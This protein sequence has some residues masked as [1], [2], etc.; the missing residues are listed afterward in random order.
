MRLSYDRVPSP[1]I[2]IEL[3]IQTDASPRCWV[4]REGERERE[5]SFEFESKPEIDLFN[6]WFMRDV[7]SEWCDLVMVRRWGGG[8]PGQEIWHY[9]QRQHPSSLRRW[10]LFDP[11]PPEEEKDHATPWPK[12]QGGGSRFPLRGEPRSRMSLLACRCAGA[13]CKWHAPCQGHAQACQA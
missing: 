2:I 11:H 4:M 13:A 5:R 1:L 12:C 9:I 8:E 10:N 3:Y 7:S 6:E